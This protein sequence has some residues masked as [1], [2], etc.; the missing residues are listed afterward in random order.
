M[1]PNEDKIKIGIV[2]YNGRMG[3]ELIK[4]A[5]QRNIAVIT[6][7]DKQDQIRSEI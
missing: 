6:E 1:L 5:Q 2:G 4:V 7:D 3:Q